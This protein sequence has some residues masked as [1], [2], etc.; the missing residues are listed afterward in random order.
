MDNDLYF[1][2]DDFLW[3]KKMEILMHIIYETK[4][5][6]I[7]IIFISITYSLFVTF[8]LY[9]SYW[10]GEKMQTNI[11]DEVCNSL[12]V[13]EWSRYHSST[14]YYLYNTAQNLLQ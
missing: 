13:S 6:C 4:K 11:G 8:I 1:L 12:H 10:F 7:K 9:C 3:K 2:Y 5:K 14:C